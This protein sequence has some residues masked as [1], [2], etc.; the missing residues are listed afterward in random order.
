M[1]AWVRVLLNG[2]DLLFKTAAAQQ[3][4]AGSEVAGAVPMYAEG[5]ML[6][7]AADGTCLHQQ[8][9]MHYTCMSSQQAVSKA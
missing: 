6:L 3:A 8:V 9:W 4:A 1:A 5:L 2:C 7:L